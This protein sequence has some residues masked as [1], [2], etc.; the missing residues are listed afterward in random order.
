MPCTP[1]SFPPRPTGHFGLVGRV[2]SIISRANYYYSLVPSIFSFTSYPL[3]G[4]KCLDVPNGDYSG[5][6]GVNLFPCHLGANQKWIIRS[7]SYTAGNWPDRDEYT[8]S[9]V[10]NPNLCLDILGGTT[11]GG[12]ALQIYPC[13]PFPTSSDNQRF[14]FPG[15]FALDSSRGVPF[16]KIG[17]YPTTSPNPDQCL[18]LW[19]QNGNGT[20]GQVQQWPCVYNNPPYDDQQWILYDWGLQTLF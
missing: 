13:A 18:D 10:G 6:N 2:V 15:Q 3:T 16:P 7:N 20:L 17:T 4:L 8:V 11:H 9:P 12:E 19:D 1:S 14:S 5:G